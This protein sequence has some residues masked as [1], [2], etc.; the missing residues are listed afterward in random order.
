M[1]IDRRYTIRLVL[2]LGGA[3]PFFFFL[4][5]GWARAALLAYALTAF[6]FGLLLVPDYPPVGTSWFW[7]AIIPIG[8][9]H[10]AIVFGLVWL[11]LSIP[12]MNRLPRMLYGFVGIIL[13]AEWW[14][15]RRIIDASQP[16][17][18]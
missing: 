9:L 13:M 15:S 7:K 4:H 1:T 2:I 5:T 16:R 18:Q 11:N 17:K 14:L 3:I 8:A 6:L 10:S 12:E